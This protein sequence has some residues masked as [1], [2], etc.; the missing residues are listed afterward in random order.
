MPFTSTNERESLMICLQYA[1]ML[2]LNH[3]INVSKHFK[4]FQNVKNACCSFQL[5][6]A[7]T[8][9]WLLMMLLHHTPLLE[10]FHELL[11]MS[12]CTVC[13]CLWISTSSSQL[14]SSIGCPFH[15]T[16]YSKYYFLLVFLLTLL[17]TM[18]SISIFSATGICFVHWTSLCSSSSPTSSAL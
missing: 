16:K 18:L 13:P 2:P 10:N 1:S 6:L 5:S 4:T 9:A 15:L 7:S 3:Y 11:F 17:S 14:A 12:S 8:L